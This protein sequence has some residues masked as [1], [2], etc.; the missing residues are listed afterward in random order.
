MLKGLL[1]SMLFASMAVAAPFAA[2]AEGPIP[3]RRDRLPMDVDTM[4]GISR[5]MSLLAKTLDL[6]VA[7]NRRAA[8]QS[9]ALAVALDPSNREARDQLSDLA[10]E[11]NPAAP[12]GAEVDRAKTQV[13]NIL[14]W[15]EAS[16]AGQDGQALGACLL[17]VLV[18][19]DPAN[20][21]SQ[22][23]KGRSDPGQWAEWVPALASYEEQVNAKLPNPTPHESPVPTTEGSD[24]AIRRKSAEVATPLWTYDKSVDNVLIHPMVISMEAWV[25]DDEIERRGFDVSLENTE[26]SWLF[27]KTSR[28]AMTALKV[29]DDRFPEGGCVL[30]TV[31]KGVDYNEAK[32]RQTI[33]AATAVLMDA[34]VSGREPHAT[35]MGIVSENGSLKMPARAW[36]K[37]RA[38]SGGSGGRLVLPREAEDMLSSV[39]VVED[40]AFFM[41]FEVILADNLKELIEFSAKDGENEVSDASA[42]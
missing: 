9:L 14:S 19:L 32:N 12:D 1:C 7:L 37:L 29:L 24:S 15:L 39:L 11:K 16:E 2:P 41:K 21:K 36:D 13:W 6:E 30:L 8:A 42:K 5:Q 35:V 38:L 17:D 31:G 25:D 23:G 4:A 3:F 18:I 10:D 26:N 40:P 28:D 27:R 22:A 20:P 33:S 34:A